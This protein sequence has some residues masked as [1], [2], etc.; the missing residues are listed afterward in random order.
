[1]YIG[2]MVQVQTR[3]R[4]LLDRLSHVGASI[5]YDSVLRLSS[6]IGETVMRQFHKEFVVCPPKMRGDGFTTAA[7]DRIDHNPSSTTSNESFHGTGISLFQHPAF[8]G[9]GVDCS[10]VIV[11]SAVYQ[12][13]VGQSPSYYTE[14]PPVVSSTAKGPS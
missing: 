11:G 10:I 4:E 13:T 12:K 5:T 9:Q 14:V 8:A 1:M 7:V 3:K 2:L 6:E